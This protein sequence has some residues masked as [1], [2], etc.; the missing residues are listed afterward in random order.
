MP[1]SDDNEI[2][3]SF[4]LRLLTANDVYKPH[5]FSIMKTMKAQYQAKK[6]RV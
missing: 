2:I 4:N 3:R 6:G 5:Q 1:Q